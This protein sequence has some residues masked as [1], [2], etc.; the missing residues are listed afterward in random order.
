MVLILYEMLNPLT[1]LELIYYS[2]AM[3][4]C[5]SPRTWPLAVIP[6]EIEFWLIVH[7]SMHAWKKIEK[8]YHI[9]CSFEVMVCLWEF[10]ACALPVLLA[11]TIDMKY[12]LLICL[13]VCK[14]QPISISLVE[15]S[16][17]VALLESFCATLRRLLDSPSSLF[18]FQ[19]TCRHSMM[20]IETQANKRY[21]YNIC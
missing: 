2:L 19:L 7:F 20:K 1:S 18:T 3:S 4:N 6:F 21:I 12:G 14:V 5:L 16:S 15:V 13:S 9:K 11:R 17:C 8:T 10:S